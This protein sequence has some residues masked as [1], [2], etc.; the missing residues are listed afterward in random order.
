MQNQMVGVATSDTVGAAISSSSGAAISRARSV[1]ERRPDHGLHD[2]APATARWQQSLR[3]ALS[4][5]DGALLTTDMPRELGGTGDHVTPGWLFRAG[6]ASCLT[7][8]IAMAAAADGIELATL[9]IRASSRSDTRGL[10]GMA[11]AA[12]EAIC[13]G[14]R[15]V[16]LEVRLSAPGCPEERLHGLVMKSYRC[17]PIPT[18]VLNAVPLELCVEICA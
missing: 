6:L 4:H 17:S 15:D 14:P 3:V 18:A 1:L 5:P 13:A 2:D 10:L 16:R 12:G 7:T 9:E 11:D 8:C